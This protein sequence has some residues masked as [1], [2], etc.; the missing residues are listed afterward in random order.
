MYVFPMYF[1]LPSQAPERRMWLT[2][3]PACKTAVSFYNE[4]MKMLIEFIIG[5]ALL[6]LYL[7]QEI[8]GKGGGES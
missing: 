8:F 5:I 6:P 7:F 2:N 4:S 3:T 1:L